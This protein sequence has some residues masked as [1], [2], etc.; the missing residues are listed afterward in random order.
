MAMTS[1]SGH[2]R[3]GSL[4]RHR[5]RGFVPLELLED[6]RLLSALASGQTQAAAV[7]KVRGTGSN[8]VIVIDRNPAMPQDIRVFKNGTLLGEKPAAQVKAFHVSTGAGNDVVRVDQSVAAIAVKPGGL[9]RFRH[10]P[11]HWWFGTERAARRRRGTTRSGDQE[12]T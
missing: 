2:G 7:W 3:N 1:R 12:R 8:D 11:R 10:R 5:R 4:P 6:R 9:C